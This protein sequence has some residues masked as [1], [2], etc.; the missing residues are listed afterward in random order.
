MLRK[1]LNRLLESGGLWFA[2]TMIH[3]TTAFITSLA[4]LLIAIIIRWFGKNT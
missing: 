4:Y 2:T 3:L 1:I